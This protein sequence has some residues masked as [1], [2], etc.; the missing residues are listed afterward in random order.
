MSRRGPRQP[1]PAVID[2][3][4]RTDLGG[5]RSRGIVPA[6]LG[7]VDR[8]DTESAVRQV[9]SAVGGLVLVALRGRLGIEDAGGWWVIGGAGV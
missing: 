2:G 4:V 1:S 3:D 8:P 5:R 6:T 9:A 7:V